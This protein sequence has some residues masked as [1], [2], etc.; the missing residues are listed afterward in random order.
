MPRESLVEE[1][2]SW[3]GAYFSEDDRGIQVF[4]GE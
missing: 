3:A 1:D 4:V 2:S